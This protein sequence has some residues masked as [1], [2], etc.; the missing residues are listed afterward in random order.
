M[1]LSALGIAVPV[2][3][4]V[5]MADDD[6]FARHC[7]AVAG[8]LRRPF[9]FVPDAGANVLE[10]GTLQIVTPEVGGLEVKEDQH[11]PPRETCE[12][13]RDPDPHCIREIVEA[14]VARLADLPSPCAQAA[15]RLGV[16]VLAVRR[17][18]DDYIH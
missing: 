7:R 3:R 1:T 10:A 18:R 6:G 16:H 4:P 17:V 11:P 8:E 12:V 9:A 13:R 15:P 5:H 2:L 14:E